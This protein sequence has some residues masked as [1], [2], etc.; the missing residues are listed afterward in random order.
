MR[1]ML[2]IAAGVCA[3]SAARAQPS[4]FYA[5]GSNEVQKFASAGAGFQG[6]WRWRAEDHLTAEELGRSVDGKTHAFAKIDECKPDPD[7]RHI[8][9]TASTGG[10]ALLELPSGRVVFRDYIPMAHSIE[11]LPDE[12]LVVAAS[13]NPEGD[14]LTV[15]ELLTKRPLLQVPFASAHG[16]VWNAKRQ[17]LYAIGKT[18][19]AVFALENWNGAAPSLRLEHSEALPG[20]QTGHDLAEID[21]DHLLFSTRDSVWQIDL[22]D[23]AITPFAPLAGHRNIK[24][25]SILPTNGRVL[26][27]EPEESWWAFKARLLSPAETIATPDIHLYK[28]RW[29]PPQ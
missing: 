26:Y 19:L 10:V 21:A 23:N 5:C 18:V 1:Y 24:S 4:A 8:M 28:L 17:R 3:F 11:R 9:V 16:V 25:V 14:R 15:F 27:Q 12:R 6:V 29:A 2:L 13:D 20:E 22:R 7:G